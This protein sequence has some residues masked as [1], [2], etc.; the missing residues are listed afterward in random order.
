MSK[1]IEKLILVQLTRYLTGR[2][3][4]CFQ[5][6][7]PVSADIIT[8]RQLAILGALSDIY[9]AIHQDQVYLLALLDVSAAF[10]AV[11]HGILL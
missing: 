10:D 7:N 3:M 2:L 11:N 9:S 4:D 1:V 6:I 5:N 8:P